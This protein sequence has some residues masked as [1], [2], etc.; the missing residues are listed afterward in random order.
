MRANPLHSVQGSGGTLSFDSP[1]FVIGTKA[2]W[3]GGHRAS[4]S[5]VILDHV[6]FLSSLHRTGSPLTSPHAGEAPGSVAASES[7]IRR[8]GPSNSGQ[9]DAEGIV[10]RLREEIE[11][12]KQQLAEKD[13]ELDR[14]KRRE[15]RS[16]PTP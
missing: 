10:Y 4:A 1:R 6:E 15:S 2:N 16:L 3:S 14:F 7:D 5:E 9:V 8:S 11:R 13:A 12:L